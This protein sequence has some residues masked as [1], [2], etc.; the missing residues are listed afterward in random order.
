MIERDVLRG[1]VW[2]LQSQIVWVE[3]ILNLQWYA[4]STHCFNTTYTWTGSHHLDIW[5]GISGQT[6]T[7]CSNWLIFSVT[8]GYGAFCWRGNDAVL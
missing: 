6:L 5:P 3:N 4:V 1:L 7:K 2:G 8:F